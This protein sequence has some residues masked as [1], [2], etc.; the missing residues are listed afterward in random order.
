MTTLSTTRDLLGQRRIVP[1]LAVMTVLLTACAQVGTNSM[2]FWDVIFSMVAF[3]F[4]FMFIWIFIA[5][6][7]D[8]FRRNDLS[9][10]MKAVWLILLVFLPFLGAIIYMIARPKVTAQDVELMTRAEA[11]SKAAA[12]VSP[13]DQIAKLSE[14]KASGAISEAEYEALKQ[15]AMAG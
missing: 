4:W 7:G 6:F 3:F 9:G 1:L 15:K 2:T 13:A 10:G 14:L 11:A 5:L 8:I 12:A